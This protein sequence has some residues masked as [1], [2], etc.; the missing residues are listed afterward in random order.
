M[1]EIEDLSSAI[2]AIYDAAV[3]PAGWSHALCKATQFARGTSA[4]L[5]WQDAASNAGV[6]FHSW[7]CND[8]YERLY[9]EKYAALNPYFP[10]LA[11]V[12]VGR[13]LSGGDL[14]PHEE[15]HRTRFFREWVK[16]QGLLDVLGISLER[17]VATTAFLSIRRSEADGLV[18]DEAKRRLALMAPHMKRAVSIGKVIQ[19][20]KTTEVVLK[21]AL[22]RVAAAVVLVTA[23]GK[24]V[25]ANQAADE[26]FNSKQILISRRGV[27]GAV[28]AVADRL[29]RE[30]FA[31]AEHGDAALGLKGIDIPLTDTD[32]RHHIAN[33]LSIAPDTQRVSDAG[34]AV[35]ALFV[36]R[37]ALSSQSPLEAAGRRYQLTPSELRVLGAV[38]EAGS[39]DDMAERLGV[40]KATV[41][42]HLNHLLAKT[43]ARR[44]TDL[45]RLVVGGSS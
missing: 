10:A 25:F 26:L 5:S 34:M 19:S 45:I 40:S 28:D 39:V 32:G 21:A 4:T 7:N 37:I 30:A 43:G 11:F 18:D 29:L 31:A 16:P 15:F 1:S 35:A 12:E 13:V 22:E 44:Q 20:G 27:A 6:T 41:K 3:D 9:F 23:E 17:T 33:V 14:I 2:E 36:R 8:D 38:L 42:T 24:I